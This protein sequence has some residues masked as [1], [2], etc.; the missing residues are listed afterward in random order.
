MKKAWLLSLPIVVLLLIVLWIR[1][2][3]QP[4][5][6]APTVDKASSAN[7]PG[8]QGKSVV[9]TDAIPLSG[10]LES[11]CKAEGV[12]FE[13]VG[14]MWDELLI[15]AAFADES[16]DSWDKFLGKLEARY[17]I[18]PVYDKKKP[19]PSQTLS[20]V[21]QIGRFIYLG[22]DPAEIRAL[23]SLAWG[24]EIE[25]S[26]A[27]DFFDENSAHALPLFVALQSSD[28]DAQVR[29]EATQKLQAFPE[30]SRAIESTVGALGDED[31]AVRAAARATLVWI[32]DERVLR[33]LRVA[34]RNPDAVVAE[35]ATSILQENLER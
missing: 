16:G 22:N 20:S 6:H 35:M 31:E 28:P 17:G 32:G 19:G 21:K 29:I 25:R 8:E 26:D 10:L 24:D 2:A 23:Q 14:S 11:R 1:F 7:G 3:H 33:A 15:P 13:K 34:T 5:R 18:I 4:A 30:S 12:V 27:L 9:G